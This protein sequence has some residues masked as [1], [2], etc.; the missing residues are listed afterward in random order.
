MSVLIGQALVVRNESTVDINQGN[1]SL[2]NHNTLETCERRLIK[3]TNR[4]S[5]RHLNSESIP[6]LYRVIE[7]IINCHI[8]LI[9]YQQGKRLVVKV[10]PWP[11]MVQG[12]NPVFLYDGWIENTETYSS[13][14]QN[15]TATSL[16]T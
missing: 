11:V 5:Y 4:L 16:R 13:F 12:Q 9:L 8:W 15:K 14:R 1:P 2:K 10:A 3:N 7:Y 6:V